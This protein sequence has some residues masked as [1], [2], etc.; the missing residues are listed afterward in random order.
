MK[1]IFIIIF[2]FMLLLYCIINLYIIKKS[3]NEYYKCYNNNNSQYIQNDYIIRDD[4]K[5]IFCFWND[6][7]L[8]P[9]INECVKKIKYKMPEWTIILLNDKTIFELINKSDLPVNLPSL[10][11]QAKTDWYR[12]YLLYNYGG[13]WLDISIVLNDPEEINKM[14]KKVAYENIDIGCFSLE[15]H[16]FYFNNNKY[17]CIEN[18]CLLTKAKNSIIKL[19]LYEFE[20]AISIGF[21][22]YSDYIYKNKFVLTNTPISK[23]IYHTAYKC[24]MVIIQ[25]NNID[26]NKIYMRDAEK[27]IFK[28]HMKFDWNSKLIINK[29]IR[30]REYCNIKIIGDDRKY[31]D[32]NI[33][34]LKIF[35]KM[36]FD[37]EYC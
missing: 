19:W 24:F 2:T 16:S 15:K 27:T 32:N 33:H 3:K 17:V 22:Q 1:L 23:G 29:L 9:L 6:K 34:F 18:S 21:N 25:K 11:I 5:N 10:N 20:Y 4:F 12:L 8:P 36:Y 30:S 14:Y 26:F 7:F 28:Y 31:F 13:L 35:L 37:I